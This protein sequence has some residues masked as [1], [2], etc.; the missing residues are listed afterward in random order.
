MK[1]KKYQV[2]GLYFKTI[3]PFFPPPPSLL[4]LLLALTPLSTPQELGGHESL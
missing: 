1:F 4:S 2:C 3:A